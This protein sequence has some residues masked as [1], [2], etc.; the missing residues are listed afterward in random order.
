MTGIVWPEQFAPG[1]S[2]VHVRNELAMAAPA[3]AVWAWLVRAERWPEW[4]V[5]SHGV[6]I[7]EAGEGRAGEL[8]LGTRFLWRTFGVAID[9]TVAELVAGERIA[10][11]ARGVGV[12]AYH[13]WL[14]TPAAGGC[15]VVTEET[16]NGWAARLGSL[17]MPHRMHRYHQIWL[18]SLARQAGAGRRPG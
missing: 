18:E 9:S 15:R 17:V 6:R 16:Q 3:A 8:G 1:R 10:W 4:Y 7:V 13:A 14:L 12:R 2:A 5:N 11:T